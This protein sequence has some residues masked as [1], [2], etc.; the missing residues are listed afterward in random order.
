M[1]AYP[2]CGSQGRGTSRRRIAP[3]VLARDFAAAAPKRVWLADITYIPTDEGL[4]YLAAVMDLLAAR[5][6]AGQFAIICV[7]NWQ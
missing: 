3:N 7:L 1:A 2:P 5:S 6:S 4:L